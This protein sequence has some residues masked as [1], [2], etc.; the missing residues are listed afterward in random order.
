MSSSL[1]SNRKKRVPVNK[2]PAGAVLMA[3]STSLDIVER[4]HVRKNC[5]GKPKKIYGGWLD[6]GGDAL[7][8]GVGSGQGRGC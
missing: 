8:G 6:S 1:T 5:E 7:A 2:R 3:A 4:F